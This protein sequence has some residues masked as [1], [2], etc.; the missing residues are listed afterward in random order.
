MKLPVPRDAC[1]TLAFRCLTL[2][3][4][5]SLLLVALE[6]LDLHLNIRWWEPTW[7]S[8]LPRAREIIK[9]YGAR[10]VGQMSKIQKALTSHTFLPMSGTMGFFF[11]IWE[12]QGRRK[13]VPNRHARKPTLETARVS[14]TMSNR[15]VS[16]K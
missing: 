12:S 15:M 9:L 13:T 11:Y 4:R 14:N 5:R 1:S 2:S 16:Q 6:L 10:V 7:A 8:S 3:E